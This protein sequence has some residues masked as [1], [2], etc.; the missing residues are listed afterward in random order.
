M[1]DTGRAGRMRIERRLVT[2]RHGADLLDRKRQ[3]MTDELERL[4]LNADRVSE[5]WSTRARDATGWLQ[6]AAALDGYGRI[7][8]TA[9]ARLAEVGITWGGAMGVGFPE[10][11]S[12]D[13]PAITR[14]GGTSALRYAASTHHAALVA[15]AQCAAAERA[16]RLVQT[17]LAATRL[18]QRAVEHRWI[19]RLERE[20]DAIRRRLAEQELEE[21]LRLR[22]AADLQGGTIGPRTPAADEDGAR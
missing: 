2:A 21:A 12:C 8:E 20:L 5:E 4:Q 17:E 16:V 11:V 10:S 1:T 15:G 6:R 9:P 13:I 7:R 3:I 19:P 14:R 22:W 18:R